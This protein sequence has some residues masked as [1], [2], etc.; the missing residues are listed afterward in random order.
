MKERGGQIDG[1]RRG[2]IKPYPPE[3]TTF[4]KPSL[5]R[6]KACSGVL[7]YM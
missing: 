6:V 1:G 7:S 3:K 5:T 4:K 2:Q